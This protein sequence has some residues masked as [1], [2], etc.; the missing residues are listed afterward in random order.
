M[1]G[2]GFGVGE[3]GGWGGGGVCTRARAHTRVRVRGGG[4]RGGSVPLHKAP[5]PSRGQKP[6]KPSTSTARGAQARTQLTRDGAEVEH[7]PLQ[8]ALLP[9]PAHQPAQALLDGL[10]E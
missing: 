7:H 6:F 8:L 2:L 9:R 4:G 5:Y 10:Q 3:G 1:W